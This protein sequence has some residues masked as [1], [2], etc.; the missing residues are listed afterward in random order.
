MHATT[1]LGEFGYAFALGA[2]TFA[3]VVFLV[4]VATRDLG[5][6]RACGSG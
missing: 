1:G 6:D 3:R 2:A 5:A 4:A